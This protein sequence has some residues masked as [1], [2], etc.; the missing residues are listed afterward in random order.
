L[1]IRKDIHNSRY[2]TCI[3]NTT[4]GKLTIGDQWRSWHWSDLSW[5]IQW[6]RWQC[7]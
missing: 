5:E 2:A 6:F 7:R 3:N 1:K 4:G